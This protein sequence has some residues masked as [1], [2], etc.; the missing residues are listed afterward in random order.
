[1][2]YIG[3]AI[4][5]PF[6]EPLAYSYDG[7][8]S[9]LLGKRIL[10][11]FRNKEVISVVVN[12]SIVPDQ[13]FIKKVK[14]VIRVFEEEPLFSEL[15]LKFLFWISKYYHE[16][17]G[18]VIS[19][20]LP[21]RIKAGESFDILGDPKWK[22]SEVG[23]LAL[24]SI[25]KR[26]KKLIEIMGFI[27]DKDFITPTIMNEAFKSWRPHFKAIQENSW[28]DESFQSC[29]GDVSIPPR[30]PHDLNDEQRVVVES[31]TSSEGFGAFLIEGVTGSGK[32]E[33]YL[34]IIEK[35]IKEGKQ[36][37]VLIPEIGLTPQT[38]SRFESYLGVKIAVVHSALN[39]KERHCAWDK[40][41][42]GQVSVLLGTRSSLFT[43]FKNL[44]VCVIDEEHDS[45]YKQQDGFRYSAK[46]SLVKR[47]HIEGVPVVLGSA[48]PSFETLNNAI[49][50]KFKHL[51]LKNRAGGSILPD[52][53]T[54]DIRKQ[55]IKEGVSDVVKQRMDAHLASGNQVLLFLNKRGFSPIMICDGCGW[56]AECP[57]CDTKMVFHQK[58]NQLRCHHCGHFERPPR[59]CPSCHEEDFSNVGQG[60]ER[61]ELSL[62]EMFPNNSV[63][64][65]DRDTTSTKNKME[66]MISKAANHEA[67]ILIGTQMLAKGHHFPDV[68]L[69][70]I[71][72]IDQGFFSSD[73]RGSEKMGQLISQVSGRAGREKKRGEV[74]IQTRQPDNHHLKN[75]IL[76]GYDEF[77]RELLKDR[78]EALLPP[79]SNQILIRAEHPDYNLPQKFLHDTA[80]FADSLTSKSN[81]GQNHFLALG[82]VPSPMPKKQ[83]RY[84]FQLL[85]DCNN[86]NMLHGFFS[87][88]ENFMYS[89]ELSRKIRWSID[90][91]PNDMA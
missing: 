15:D 32:T 16:P 78:K 91:D 64:R 74:L 60:T 12:T 48:T 55:K 5:G 44:G 49:S 18:N 61:L 53:K 38:V 6:R 43:P 83:N 41:R 3:V 20:A 29:L 79:F 73:Y 47:A 75:L 30:V 10:V 11:S 82:P 40:V 31:V 88:I 36:A 80:N 19:T 8:V 68:T 7:D 67:D 21:K 27:K 87:Q 39:D 76:N 4:P 25:P 22:I 13:S 70:V 37:L 56:K 85:I 69:V 9:D 58:I 34:N 59:I 33:V 72:D 77:S 2:N 89:H 66:D 81:L 45:S 86:R 51:F 23:L 26:S 46:D 71:L 42:T 57:N 14:P 90:V 54:V 35:Y 28:V 17:I 65:I 63:L 50:G 62:E 1:M 84:R 52:V 24:D